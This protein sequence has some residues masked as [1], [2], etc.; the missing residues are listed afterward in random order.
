MKSIIYTFILF[1]G[2]ATAAASGHLKLMSRASSQS[3]TPHDS[4][5][6]SV[7]VL[8]CHINTNR[9]AYWPSEVSC[10]DICVKV[11]YGGRSLHLLKIDR[12][13]GAH[14]ISYDA[15]NYLVFG[16]SA[17]D[18]PHMGGG[19]QMITEVV[20]VSECSDLLHNGK[21]P[22]SAPNSVNYI[23]NCLEQPKS[24]VAKNYEFI[25]MLDSSCKSGYDEVCT[26]DL[27]TSN[28]PQCPHQLGVAHAPT[29]Q[30]VVNIEYGT[31]KEVIA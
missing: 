19:V 22:V 18:E 20:P 5:S 21:L 16:K 14:D 28:Q 15:W 9:V 25:N 7:G 27:A 11:A 6:S 4:F 17:K 12:S 31:G 26:F 10:D 24:F 29:G 23:A 3:I 1:A 13:G 8:G 2:T 30:K